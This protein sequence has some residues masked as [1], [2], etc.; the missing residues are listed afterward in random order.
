MIDLSRYTKVAVLIG[1][2]QDQWIEVFT[3]P[4]PDFG[5]P[6]ELILVVNL[7][8]RGE[9]AFRLRRDELRALLGFLG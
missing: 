1:R 8:N 5:V 2:H 9:R 6:D 4:M 7:P 3:P